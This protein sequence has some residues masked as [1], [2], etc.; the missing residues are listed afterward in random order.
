MDRSLENLANGR[1]KLGCPSLS[2]FFL[3]SGGAAIVDKFYVDSIH[4]NIDVRISQNLLHIVF[5]PIEGFLPL[6]TFVK[7]RS[8]ERLPKYLSKYFTRKIFYSAERPLAVRDL[9]TE[10]DSGFVK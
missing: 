1:C 9:G 10:F 5:A 8:S 6:C 4:G 3:D 7:L 2:S